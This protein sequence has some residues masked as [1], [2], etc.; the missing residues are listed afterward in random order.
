M[1][2]EQRVKTLEY[3][4]KIL[5]NEIQRTLLDIQEQV[6]VH[7][8]PSLRSADAQAPSEGAVQSLESIRGRRG[9]SGEATPAPSPVK[10]IS[11]AEIEGGD[12]APAA[13]SGADQRSVH[14]TQWVGDSVS[15]IGQDRT[16]KLIETCVDKGWIS[17]EAQK[18]LIRLALMSNDST[19]PEMVAINEILAVLL[20]LNQWLGREVDVEEAL[21]LIEEANLG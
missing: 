18:G 11:L 7:Y 5:K 9:A 17:P 19:A 15:R 6:L 12:S 10:K 13:A 4:I 3:E 16:R 2:L 21:S 1:E 20:Q 8:Y 14:L